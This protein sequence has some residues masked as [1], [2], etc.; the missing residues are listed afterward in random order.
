MSFGFNFRVP[1]AL[2]PNKS[3]SLS[4]DALNPGNDLELQPVISREQLKIFGYH[5]DILKVF[6][7][8]FT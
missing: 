1:A 2:A 5:S 7:K 3:V 6:M 4:F 8:I